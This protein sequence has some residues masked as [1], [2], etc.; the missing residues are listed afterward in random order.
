MFL[1]PSAANNTVKPQRIQIVDV[2][3]G[4]ALCGIIFA[5]LMSFTGFYSLSL[6]QVQLLP[7]ADRAVLFFID[8][9][10]EGK[11][12]TV[13]AILLGAGFAIQLQNFSGSSV[14]F[15][16]FWLKRMMILMLIGI[17]HMYFIWHGDILTLY[18][19]LGM[20]MVVFVRVPQKQLLIIITMLLV[21]PWLIHLL[22]VS[23][24]ISFESS[25]PSLVETLK[26][27]LGYKGMTL[28]ELRTS[29]NAIDVFFANVF[30]A[31]PRPIAYLKTGRPFQLLGHFLLGIYLARHFLLFPKKRSVL[32]LKSALWLFFIGLILNITYAIIKAVTGSPFTANALGL[33]QGFV[34]HL[35]S[36]LLA[37]SYMVALSALA[38]NNRF[39]WLNKL[40]VLGKMS[41][42]HYLMQTSICVLIFYGYGLSLMGKV[43]FTSIV[44]FGTTILCVQYYMGKYWLA[45]F[46]QGPMEYLWRQLSNF[47]QPT[48]HVSKN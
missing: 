3:R 38:K 10:I 5:N 32:S 31:I 36:L 45:T 24:T 30:S 42:T 40:A 17:S 33:F 28:L 39:L 13:F 34:Y 26:Q 44:A 48:A 14:S 27:Q 22:L 16:R 18:S 43:P 21:T 12:Y 37:L 15:T 9:F 23:N 41:L 29:S 1:N 19:L 8:C 35:G 46:K 25:S 11:F 20:I 4:F 6:S 2:M 47:R 7:W